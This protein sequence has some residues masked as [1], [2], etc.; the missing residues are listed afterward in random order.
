M[1]EQWHTQ[2][3][4]YWKG[5]ACT[6]LGRA[7]TDNRLS[8]LDDALTGVIALASELDLRVLRLEKA[9]SLLGRQAGV[10]HAWDQP[11]QELLDEIA[12]YVTTMART[13]ET[14]L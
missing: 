9:V 6:C 8:E 2:Q 12:D 3:C 10:T 1:S 14:T 5:L 11:L 7:Q 4:S 13:T